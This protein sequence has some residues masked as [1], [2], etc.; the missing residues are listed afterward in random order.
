MLVLVVAYEAEA[1]VEAVLD[2]IPDE[3]LALDVEVLLV[4]DASVDRTH[5]L[6]LEY[7][8]R[9][10]DLPITVLR[11]RVNQ[12]YGGNQKVGY[13]YAIEHGFDVVAMLHGDGQYAPES[14]PALLA[15]LED[16]RVGAVFG[17]RMSVPGAALRGG[18]PRY[19]YVGNRVL[20]GF[21]NAVLRT[22]LSEYHSGYRVY[23][24]AALRE[25]HFGL[26]TDDFHF[27]TEILLQLMAAGREIREVPVPTHYGDEISRVDGLR[28]ARDV[29]AVTLAFALHRLGLRQQ[30]RFDPVRDDGDRYALKLGYPSSHQWAVDAVPPGAS[31]LDVGGGPGGV[32]AELARR[33]HRV[34]VVDVHPPPAGAFDGLDVSVVVADLDDPAT[35]LDLADWDVVLLLDVIEHLADPEGFLDRL[36]ARATHDSRLVVV[37]TPNVAFVVTRLSLLLGQFNYGRSGILDRTHR[38]LFTFRTLSHL[39]RD[40]GLFV[41][42]VR[43]VPAPVPLAIGD[44]P[45]AGALL[46]VNQALIRLSRTLFS[47]QI[48]VVGRTRPDLGF[49]LADAEDAAVGDAPAAGG[50]TP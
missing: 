1:T 13:A 29:A 6:A 20:T 46:R 7:R 32:A 23:S 49:L 12:G 25:V 37:T 45:L 16:E 40:G 9:R 15:A 2:R 4:D 5:E 17:S 28:Y 14:L 10:A 24:V 19:K 50:L 48:F 39:L 21:Q 42:E 30:R 33:G 41:E 18:M 11:N 22:S 26:N 3:V 36:R 31:V 38:R 34:G 27:D 47:F 35:T 43:G 8:D 44:G